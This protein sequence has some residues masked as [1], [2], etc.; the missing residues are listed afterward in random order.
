LPDVATPF[1]QWF[2]RREYWID[3]QMKSRAPVAVL[4]EINMSRVWDRQQFLVEIKQRFSDPPDIIAT[5][6]TQNERRW[7]AAE[8]GE[9]E[10]LTKPVAL[11]RPQSTARTIAS[12]PDRENLSLDRMTAYRLLR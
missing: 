12:E 10:L 3:P 5:A 8:D 2:C 4:S 11:E 6:Y 1:R 9:T 7:Q